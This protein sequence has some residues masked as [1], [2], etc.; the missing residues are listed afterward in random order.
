[1]HIEKKLEKN[2]HKGISTNKKGWY[3]YTNTVEN[4]DEIFLNFS[5]DKLIK[6]NLKLSQCSLNKISNVEN[7]S[8]N[9]KTFENE[10][11]HLKSSFLSN[12][13]NLEDSDIDLK[14][15]NY[16]YKNF[17]LEQKKKK[18]NLNL[19]MTFLL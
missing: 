9:E 10:T 19:V 6:K 1:F 18:S 11:Y 2:I 4:S 16:F 14:T 17:S 12:F 7:G 3:I 15:K 8:N 5:K 13:N